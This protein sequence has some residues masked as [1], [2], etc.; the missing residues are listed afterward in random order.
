MA[1]TVKQHEAQTDAIVAQLKSG[2]ELLKKAKA[3]LVAART[4]LQNLREFSHPCFVVRSGFGTSRNPT[5]H[6]PMD[7]YVVDHINAISAFL[8]DKPTEPSA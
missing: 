3:E 4:A 5:V 6:I 7:R 1:K 2:D 8:G